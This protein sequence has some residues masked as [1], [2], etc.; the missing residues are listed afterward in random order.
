[1]PPWKSMAAV[2]LNHWGLSEKPSQKHQGFDVCYWLFIV[3]HC[4]PV[5]A[6]SF[7]PVLSSEAAPLSSVSHRCSSS[8]DCYSSSSSSSSLHPSYPSPQLYIHQTAQQLYGLYSS[9][10]HDAKVLSALRANHQ[11]RFG[12]AGSSRYNPLLPHWYSSLS[13]QQKEG[14]PSW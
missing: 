3:Q 8:E 12:L 5:T 14:E 13:W 2:L 9:W 1:M 7:Y 4:C 6:F 11:R 10:E